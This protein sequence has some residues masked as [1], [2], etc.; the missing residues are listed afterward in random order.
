[1]K[2]Y[3]Q[4]PC[5][6]LALSLLALLMLICPLLL[7]DCVAGEVLCHSASCLLAPAVSRGAM[8]VAWIVSFQLLAELRSTGDIKS[9]DPR[10]IKSL[11]FPW[12]DRSG[13]R[14]P[15]GQPPILAACGVSAAA[16][17][18]DTQ[19]PCVQLS[20]LA[21]LTFWIPAVL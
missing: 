8:R 16:H 20:Y 2:R 10:D 5:L 7:M 6:S 12:C 21:F 15:A 14:W 11:G 1:M 19:P 13:T 17:H 4:P 9:P 3:M 18:P